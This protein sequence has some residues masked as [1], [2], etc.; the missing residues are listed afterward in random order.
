MRRFLILI[1]LL[2][3]LTAVIFRK[4]NA[5]RT[6]KKSQKE[7]LVGVAGGMTRSMLDAMGGGQVEV[8]E[9][10]KISHGWAGAD[11]VGEK[12]L[13]LPKET[14]EN[15]SA[16][17]HGQAALRAGLYFLL[18][19]DPQA[20]ARRRWAIR[21]GHVFPIFTTLVVV[22]AL[23]VAKL[24]FGWGMGVVMASLAVATVVQ[25]MTVQTERQAAEL[26]CVVLEKKRIFP[27]LGEEESVIAAT[28]ALAWRGILPGILDRWV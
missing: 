14:L 7:K 1:S 28:K 6:L 24:P 16:Y 5:D 4:L 18:L 26:A 20:I 12:W 15:H 2:C 10:E 17:A 13:R 27:R 25:M 23:A 19:R 3:L 9:S 11:V 22:F 8:Q 21:F